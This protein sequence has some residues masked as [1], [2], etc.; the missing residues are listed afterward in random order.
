MASRRFSYLLRALPIGLYLLLTGL[1]LLAVPAGESPDEPSHLQCIEQ[2][3]LYNRIPIIDPPPKGNVWWARDRIIS[4]LVCAHMP[5]YYFLAGYTEQIMHTITG[6]P[7]HYEFPAN[8]PEWATGSSLAMFTHRPKSPF[9]EIDEP[10]TLTTLRIE[11]ILLG[12]ISIWSGYSIAKRLAPEWP[13]ASLL[14]MTLIAGWPQFVFMSRAINNDSLAVAL[15]AG[16][17][18][19]LVNVGQPRR[20]IA[21]TILSALAILS[22]FTMIFTVG[23]IGL[24][25][26]MEWIIA[27]ERRRYL[28]AGFVSCLILV[29]LAALLLLQP[30]LRS[31]LEW[32]QKTMVSLQPAAGT[33]TYWLDVLHATVQSGWARF[34]W[35]NVFTPDALS[36]TWWIALAVLAT[37]GTFAVVHRSK[38]SSHRLAIIIACIWVAATLGSYFRINLNRFQPQFR[39][40]FS[41][42]PIVAALAA[43][44]L[45]TM[46]K[47]SGRGQ[48]VGV[49]LVALVLLLAN[50]LLIFGIVVPTYN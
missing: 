17:I 42:L 44:G 8:N 4:G 30:T 32:T 45:M 15:S 10:A 24:T 14:A 9:F 46:L 6:L 35:M 49:L 38:D 28:R 47:K 31:D 39:Y 13:Y 27:R 37:I 5:L 19:I 7:I 18:A 3:A 40:S 34:G 43:I 12:L 25:F 2:V 21:A 23:A 50:L 26:A 33:L 22:K 16:V 48:Y 20:F 1:Y 11:S 29:A 41:V 36:Y